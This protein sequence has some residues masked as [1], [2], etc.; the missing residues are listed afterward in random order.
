M[1]QRTSFVDQIY[2]N[3]ISF[4]SFLQIG[5]SNMIN[6][7]SRALAVHRETE[8]YYSNE[9]NFSEYTVF[10]QPI[11]ITPVQEPFTY[12]TFNHHPIIKVGKIDIVGISSS[13]L[14][15]VGNSKHISMEARVKHIRQ[16][17]PREN[18]QNHKQKHKL[19]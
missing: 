3:T 1:F 6:G 16:L 11:P 19:K 10:S 13:S 5:D 8:F 7:F 4:S 2:I 9:G 18:E 17:L 12:Q 14:L 15:H